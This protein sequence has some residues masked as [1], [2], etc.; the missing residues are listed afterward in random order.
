MTDDYKLVR[1]VYHP[2]T[3]HSL[4]DHIH[5][6]TYHSNLNVPP[7]VEIYMLLTSIWHS[8]TTP[9]P[10]Y[11]IARRSSLVFVNGAIHWIAHILHDLQ[12]R[13]VIMLF[14][15]KDEAF[16]EVA[17]PQSLQEP[18]DLHF[19]LAL[20]DGLLALV[21]CEHHL[22][23]YACLTVW[24]MKEY[25][26]VKSWT[27]L[28]DVESWELTCIFDKVIVFT[29]SGEVLVDNGISLG[30]SSQG[31]VDLHNCYPRENF[32]GIFLDTYVES[33]VLLNITN[34]VP[35]RH[36]CSSSGS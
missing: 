13:N 31:Y 36:G 4:V 27:H 11:I 21:S 35:R 30:P 5:R 1:L 9:D 8:I 10:P 15:M 28:F 12:F 33:L 26:V 25:G 19:S 7:L 23:G 32:F 22:H 24:V 16:G 34:Q 17:L 14:N 29:K 18:D 20:L 6:H 3:Y 2:H